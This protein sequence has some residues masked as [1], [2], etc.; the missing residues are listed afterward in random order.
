MVDVR[1]AMPWWYVIIIVMISVISV[2]LFQSKASHKDCQMG[3]RNI[4]HKY[5]SKSYL[6]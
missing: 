6:R 2:L 1:L 4:H 3:I 5:H